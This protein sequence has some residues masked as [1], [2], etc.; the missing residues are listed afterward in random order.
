MAILQ[1]ML[2]DSCAISLLKIQYRITQNFDKQKMRSKIG[3]IKFSCIP[4]TTIEVGRKSGGRRG[5]FIMLQLYLAG[6]DIERKK[7][8]K[9]HS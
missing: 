6:L 4:R 7:C 8:V 3:S 2:L 1:G 5:K 9:Y